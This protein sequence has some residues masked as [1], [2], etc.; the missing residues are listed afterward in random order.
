MNKLKGADIRAIREFGKLTLEQMRQAVGAKSL[1]TCINW[2]NGTSTPNINQFI[3]LFEACNLNAKDYF[4]ENLQFDTRS[5]KI[6][7][8]QNLNAFFFFEHHRVQ[9]KD[10]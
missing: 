10:K 5:K 2:E 1:K 9:T 3:D 8:E 7:S 6:V 4:Q